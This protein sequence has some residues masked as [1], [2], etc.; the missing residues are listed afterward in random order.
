MYDVQYTWYLLIDVMCTLHS[1]H[2]TL[3]VYLEGKVNL[4]IEGSL[5]QYQMLDTRSAMMI[6]RSI[7][8]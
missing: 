2:S 4:G 7:D 8:V 3:T 1:A 6:Y 5:K